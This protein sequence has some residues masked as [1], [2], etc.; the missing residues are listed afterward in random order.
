MDRSRIVLAAL[1]PADG[2]KLSPVQVQKLLFLI[3]KRV[4]RLVAGPHFNFQPYNYGPFDKR[5]YAELER[6]ARRGL[7]DVTH[8]RWPSYSLTPAGQAEG[9][10]TLAVLP[11]A[12]AD[13][14]RR[15]TEFVR[16]LSFTDLV[17][18]IYRAYPEMRANSVFQD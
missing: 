11:P 5:V 4:P 12:A 6:L 8:G 3:D 10:A 17:A 2:A 7:V 18:S 9:E 14:I 15:A 13:F 1:A 16:S